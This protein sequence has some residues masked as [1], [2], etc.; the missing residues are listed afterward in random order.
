MDI[1]PSKKLP[2]FSEYVIAEFSE[3]KKHRRT[4]WTFPI[5]GLTFLFTIGVSVVLGRLG[6]PWMVPL[7]VF[8]WAGAMV[9]LDKSLKAPKTAEERYEI[10]LEA[11]LRRYAN[12]MN[13]RRL[14]RDLD[15]TA[16][17]LLEAS[18]YYWSKIRMQLSSPS[19]S[20]DN[21]PLHLQAVRQQTLA[22]INEAMREQLALCVRCLAAPGQKK[23][24]DLRELIEDT[25][26]IDVDDALEALKGGRSYKKG[27]FQSERLPEIFDQSRALAEKLKALSGEIDK[28]TFDN[29]QKLQSMGAGAT[30]SIDAALRNLSEIQTAQAELDNPDQGLRERF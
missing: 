23:S 20:G 26:G 9:A 6:L 25:L 14:H 4:A 16:A 30:L 24:T 27:G 18:A 21:A 17:Q 8:G 29:M 11:L 15:Y 19:W 7:L 22:A 5:A 1:T 12:S 28:M 3:L 2:Y 10:E 13:G